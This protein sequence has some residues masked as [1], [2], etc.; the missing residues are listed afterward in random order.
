MKNSKLIFTMIIA[1]FLLLSG[2]VS[3]GLTAS[4]HRT[5]VQ[6]STG[7]YKIVA[8]N[9]SGEASSE[10]LLGFSAGFGMASSQF[11][12]IPI[13]DNRALFQQAMRDMWSKFEATHGS[14]ANRKLALI[15]F[16][17]DSESLNTFFYT[18]LTV[19]VVADIIEFH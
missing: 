7:N 6:L 2:C 3:T 14:P 12:I 1:F 16:R 5:D 17:Y 8:T 13:S 11:A 9:I 10:A 15:N 18:Q 19:T 4:S